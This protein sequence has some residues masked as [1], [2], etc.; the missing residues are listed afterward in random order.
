ML[1]LDHF[2]QPA[3]TGEYV[4]CNKC[5]RYD[6]KLSDGEA[7]D[8]ELWGMQS[9]LSLPL[10]P[11]LLSLKVILPVKVASTYQIELFNHLQ[12]LTNS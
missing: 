5:P 3:M 10:L 6:T 7:P 12:Y 1:L 9:T 8:L 4:N 11:S 2:G